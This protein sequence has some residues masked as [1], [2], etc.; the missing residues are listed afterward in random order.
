MRFEPSEEVLAIARALIDEV[1]TK[2]VGTDT[3]EDM[4]LVLTELLAN[5]IRHGNIP[6]GERVNVVVEFS[7]DMVRI[8]VENPGHASP[9]AVELG[10]G[11]RS[12]G[13]GLRLVH[14]LS[15]RWGATV[16]GITRVWAEIPHANG[17]RP[18]PRP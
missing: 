5:A 1:A 18:D 6:D 10:E 7:D 4:K 15:A 17:F 8:Q 13:L 14:G 2:R 16:N 12:S 9:F 3:I 11:L